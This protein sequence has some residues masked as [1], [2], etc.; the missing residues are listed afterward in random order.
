MELSVYRRYTFEAA[1]NL[2]WHPGKCR[3]LHGHSY[4]LEV[5]ICG[6]QD[7]RG[8]VLDFEE[9]DRV[10]SPVVER[11]DHQLLNDII[12]NPTAECVVTWISEQLPSLTWRTLR[13]WETER[14]SAMLRR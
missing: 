5:E 12:E 7:A 11:L 6:P 13:L 10:V 2:A 14:G 9:I 1:H 4:V 3:R 8:V